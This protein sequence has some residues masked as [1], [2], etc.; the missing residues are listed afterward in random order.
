MNLRWY[1]ISVL[2][3]MWAAVALSFLLARSRGITEPLT[4]VLLMFVAAVAVLV[5]YLLTVVI[6]NR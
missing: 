4:L 2:P 1:D 6:D 5:F 3:C